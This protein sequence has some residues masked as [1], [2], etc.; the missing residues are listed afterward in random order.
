[1]RFNKYPENRMTLPT[2]NQGW[3]NVNFFEL[4]KLLP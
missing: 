3:R 1:M 2:R 4:E